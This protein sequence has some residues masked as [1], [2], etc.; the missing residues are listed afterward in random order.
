MVMVSS[1]PVIF[2]RIA[3]ANP[4]VAFRSGYSAKTTCFVSRLDGG[5][6]PSETERQERC[7]QSYRNGTPFHDFN[8]SSMVIFGPFNSS[9]MVIFGP[10]LT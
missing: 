5:V 7:K 4:V 10:S 9:S 3:P 2:E 8:S 6:A 1:L